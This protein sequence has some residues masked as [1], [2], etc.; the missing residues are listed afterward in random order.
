MLLLSLI[1]MRLILHMTK[2]GRYVTKLSCIVIITSLKTE[3]DFQIVCYNSIFKIFSDSNIFWGTD[4][5]SLS[6]CLLVFNKSYHHL[7]P[8]WFTCLSLGKP[9][10]LWPH[11]LTHSILVSRQVMAYTKSPKMPPN[12]NLALLIPS[13]T[14]SPCQRLTQGCF[15]QISL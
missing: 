4:K 8:I 13:P 7:I 2:A 6:E 15:S 3:F 10:N 5:T 1:I 12:Y 9:L 14:L 11:D